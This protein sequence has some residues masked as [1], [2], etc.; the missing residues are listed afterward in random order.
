MLL[1]TARIPWVAL[2]TAVAADDTLLETAGDFSYSGAWPS[3]NT[4]NLRTPPLQDANGVL[5]AFHGTAAADKDFLYNL[6]GRTRQNGPI[7][8]LLT[9]V[10]TLG[11]QNCIISPIDN[12][13]SI[14]NGEWAGTITATG[15]IFSGLVEILDSGN[16]RIC[17]LKFDT[18]HLEDLFCEIDLDGGSDAATLAYGIITGY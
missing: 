7:Q 14:T 11:T 17:M 5:I 3:S 13:T 8:L 12:S 4:I 2:R 15:G 9:G 18:L 16:N 10:A 1:N 6:Y